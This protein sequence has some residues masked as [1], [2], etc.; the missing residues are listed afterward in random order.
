MRV[1]FVIPNDNLSGGIKVVA[2]Y[3]RALQQRGHEVLVVGNQ[4]PARRMSRLDRLWL[5]FGSVID[6]PAPGSHFE[7]G[8]VEL[9]LLPPARKLKK[10]DLPD[11]DIVIATFWTT[12]EFVATLPES[13]GRK[14]YLIQ[15]H[16]IHPGQPLERIH[17]TFRSSMQKIVVSEW[18]RGIMADEYGD[19]A[20]VL[21]PNGVDCS[22]FH[23]SRRTRNGTPTVGYLHHI[24]A[25][26][27]ADIA[28]EAIACARRRYPELR[29]IAFGRGLLADGPP[30][31]GLDEYY[32][33]PA[34]SAIRDIYAACDLWLFPSRREGFGL[35]LL[36]A[37][38]C[39]TPLVAAPAGAAPEI[40]A[41]G[42]GI[43]VET[44]DPT[45]MAEGI[46][47]VLEMSGAEWEVLSARC[48]EIARER[49][50]FA[51]EARL[52]SVLEGLL[53]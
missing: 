16:E 29:S 5:R 42:A 2:I 18:L 21:V 20:A 51:S 48:V 47:R 46:L 17:A 33:R 4:R 34:Q 28:I 31:P 3:A 32:Y 13:K 27:G 37:A 41:D 36:E 10:D 40:I 15:G 11:A 8:G 30:D 52:E 22:Q 19:T 12:A 49:D 24:A 35:P 23:A 44:D 39:G 43:L 1:T 9:R 6:S 53:Q 26:K 38:A 45:A 14:C 50:W 25:F 7:D